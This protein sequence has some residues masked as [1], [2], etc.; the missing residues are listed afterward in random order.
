MTLTRMAK[1]KYQI[2]IDPELLAELEAEAKLRGS[3][4]TA[5]IHERCRRVQPLHR[6]IDRILRTLDDLTHASTKK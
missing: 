2:R 6:K 5:I 1:I 4:V 3:D